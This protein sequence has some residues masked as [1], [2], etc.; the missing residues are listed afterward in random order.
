MDKNFLNFEK[1]LSHELNIKAKVIDAYV[2]KVGFIRIQFNPDFGTKFL[3]KH[4]EFDRGTEIFIEKIYKSLQDSPHVVDVI[5]S[6]EELLLESKK[7]NSESPL[8]FRHWITE[9]VDALSINKYIQLRVVLP[10]KKREELFT[11]FLPKSWSPEQFT[12]YYN[13]AIFAALA[14]VN[15]FPIFTDIGQ[16]ARNF[17]VDTLGKTDSWEHKDGYGP[18][19]IHP[20]FYILLTQDIEQQEGFAKPIIQVDKNENV[21]ILLSKETKINEFVSFFLSNSNNGLEKF[22]RCIVIR[23]RLRSAIDQINEENQRLRELIANYFIQS[24]MSKLFG[25]TARDI[26]K[27]LSKMHLSLLEISNLEIQLTK[28]GNNFIEYIQNSEYLRLVQNYFSEHIK[29]EQ[30]FDR[31]AQLTAM[32]FA[33]EE[34]TNNSINQ[35]TLFAAFIGAFI[36]GLITFIIQV[37]AK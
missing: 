2:L 13:G 30:E 22:Y 16:V 33:A 1:Y 8:Y 26:R 37:Y 20:N 31:N 7:R 14:P 4:E 19:P 12:I 28:A 34:A 3:A 11:S 35:A 21:F 32:N 25:S 29:V 24:I 23:H 36:G 10:K 17:I 9:K 27:T 5:P 6:Q 15:Q 18:T